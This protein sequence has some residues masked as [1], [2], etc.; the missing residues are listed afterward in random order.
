MRA[1]YVASILPLKFHHN[2]ALRL[3]L[4]GVPLGVHCR[5]CVFSH[6]CTHTVY[7]MVCADCFHSIFFRTLLCRI[8]LPVSPLDYKPLVY[9]RTTA[10]FIQFPQ[11]FQYIFFKVQKHLKSQFFS[12]LCRF[13]P[14]PLKFAFCRLYA[15]NAHKS[16][17]ESFDFSRYTRLA[18]RS[19]DWVAVLYGA[20]ISRLL[21]IASRNK[22]G[23]VVT[24]WGKK[25]A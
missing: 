3:V 22:Y 7:N 18:C 12:T 6:C 1:E 9:N 2:L 15:D 17:G 19:F 16:K 25:W 13:S 21:Y 20:I 4:S 5:K 23:F 11:S 14:M 10:L 8:L 24:F